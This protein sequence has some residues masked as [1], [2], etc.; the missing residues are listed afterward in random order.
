M[1]R[2]RHSAKQY[3]A[4]LEQEISAE[5]EHWQNIHSILSR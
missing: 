1:T 5:V 4:A 3:M 2:L